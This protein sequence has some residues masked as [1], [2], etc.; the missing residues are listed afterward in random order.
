MLRRRA[1]LVVGSFIVGTLRCP[2]FALPRKVFAITHTDAEWRAFLT[3]DQYAV[4][5]EAA[6]ET[7]GSSPL[8]QEGRR[9]VFACAGCNQNNFSSTTKFE[10]GA[11]WPSFF[12]ALRGTVDTSEDRRFGME[13]MATHC[14]QCGGHLG[15]VFNDGPRPTGLRYCINGLALT[16]KPQDRG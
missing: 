5:R 16:F 3:P 6:T 12:R 13:R 10:S 4:L 14:S 15:H 7:P 2:A 1:F 8:L 9:G 11:G